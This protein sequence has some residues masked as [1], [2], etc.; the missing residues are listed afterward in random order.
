MSY[1]SKRKYL[2]TTALSLALVC[3]LSTNAYAQ[4][5]I[6]LTLNKGDIADYGAT[7]WYTPEIDLGE[8]NM[9]FAL[10]TGTSLFWATTD[11]CVTV[12]CK[13][14][15]N[16]NTKQADFTWIGDPNNPETV[17]FGPWG[18]MLVA[19]AEVPINIS[20]SKLTETIDF[21]GSVNYSGEKFEY[22]AWGGGIG[23]PSETS[24]STSLGVTSIM[25]LLY[26][27]NVIP[28]PV[29][30]I[31]TDLQSG[32]GLFI[33]GGVGKNVVP[34]SKVVLS[35][36]KAPVAADSYLW[37]TN[38]A[39]AKIGDQPIKGLTSTLFYLDSG[40]SRFKGGASY[41]RP[42][43][44]YLYTFRTKEGDLIFKQVFDEDNQVI[45]LV[46]DK[47]RS[48]SE[49]LDI[50]PDFQMAIGDSCNG[51][52]ESQ[53]SLS[54][55]PKQYSYQPLSGEFAKTYVAA[56]RVLGG[57]EGLLVGSTVMDLIYSEFHHTVNGKE[58]SQGDMIIYQKL[59]GD[60]PKGYE[61]IDK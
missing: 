45:E 37:G 46:Y 52:T 35:P 58:L 42:I 61:C 19:T 2:K 12:A 39:S 44:K 56:F 21:K 28:E 29:F 11:L 9:R 55:G 60:R 18:S 57:V 53:L 16:V 1:L 10:D 24:A 22:L 7:Q 38:L 17:S 50:L 4:N 8:S 40:S 51:D 49:F 43:L 36:K 15:L 48:P 41:I 3:S 25:Q 34:D 33:V 23:F 47:G 59:T 14:H 6:G 27:K 26:F 32:T 5:A 31:E 54:L 13:A 30:S 20:S